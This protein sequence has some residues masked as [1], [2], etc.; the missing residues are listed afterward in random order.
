MSIVSDLITVISRLSY[1]V[2]EAKIDPYNNQLDTLPAINVKTFKEDYVPLGH[3]QDY[4][5]NSTTVV[6][7]FVGDTINYS[8]I[9]RTIFDEVINELMTDPVWF[10]SFRKPPHITSEFEYIDGG[11][12]NYAVAYLSIN[13]EHTTSF[14]P[15]ITD[16]F[17]EVHFGLDDMSPFDPN[18]VTDIGPD[19]RNE[20]DAVIILP[21]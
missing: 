18:L 19:G 1:P 11:E 16:N 15:N 13:T 10:S 12:I 14:Q 9:L 8:S 6:G 5:V 21:Q 20:I 17:A 7:I 3:G 4:L 2:T